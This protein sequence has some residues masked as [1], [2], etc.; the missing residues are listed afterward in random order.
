[1]R[2]G[3]LGLCQARGVEVNVVG[4]GVQGGQFAP[5]RLRDFSRRRV[6]RGGLGH[7]ADFPV[8]TDSSY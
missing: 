8:D 5:Q 7:P 2:P 4:R 6:P 3:Q 1:M